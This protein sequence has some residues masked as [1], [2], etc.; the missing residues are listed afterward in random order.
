MRL[1]KMSL[2]LQMAIATVLGILAGL[3]LGDYAEIFAPYSAAYIMIL[4][5]T[6]VPYLIVAIMHGVGQLAVSQAK[7]ILKKGIIF[8]CMAWMINILIIYLIKYLFPQVE[9]GQLAGYAS[10]ETTKLNFAELL[11]PDNI[12]YDLSNNVI[13]AVVIFSLLFG[14]ALM[15]LKTEKVLMTGLQHIV[16]SLTMITSW[17][18]R[19][20]PY[21]TFLIMANQ[22]GTIQFSIFKQV[23]TYIIL[24]I[25]GICIVLFWIFPRIT[26]M[27]TP[28]SAGKWLKELSP[29]LVLAYTTNVVIVCL[30]YI[31]ELLKR[32]TQLIDP[33]DD[34]AQN[35]IQ[36]TVSIV[37]NLP[38]GSLFITVFVFF[39]SNF[40][41]ITL[42]FSSQVELFVTT[43]L[44][45][46]G[47]VGLGSWI[48]SLTFILDSLS[49]PE[50]GI[51]LYLT[52]LPFT[53][54]FQSMISAMEIATI[55][56]FITLACRNR[57]RFTWGKLAKGT[58]L[59]ALPVLLI[60]SGIKLFNPLPPIKN[61]T[62]SII[63]L[64]ISSTNPAKVLKQSIS[65]IPVEKDVF[66]RILTT[67]VLRVGYNSQAIPFCFLNTEGNVVG[68]DMAFAYELAY[69]LDCSLELVPLNYNDLANELNQG[70]YDIAMSAVTVNE[71]RLKKMTF[72]TSYMTP[73]L[74][75]LVKEVKRKQFSKLEKV[76]KLP[77][78]KIAVLKGSSFESIAKE[79]FPEKSLILL[80]SYD[81]F[82][83][84][85]T[86]VALLWEEQE[87][88][89]WSIFHRGFRVLLPD[90]SLGIDSLAYAIQANNSRFLH[91]L[92]EWLALKKA[93]GFTE[94]QVD[95]WIKGKTDIAAPDE[96]RWSI[97]RDILHW[98]D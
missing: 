85:D 97:M 31:I 17:I 70:T 94:K 68:Y 73:R 87:A 59:T 41:N 7:Q 69:D 96:L 12:F 60:A 65:S 95:L 40:Y 47:A 88:L 28:L 42:S 46:L 86:N 62:K 48:N 36:G 43:F 55:S 10:L 67:K 34:K 11:I 84:V 51:G 22:V 30:P 80:N 58:L 93:Q 75:F 24:Y 37:F 83:H 52:T 81:E 27:L 23:S 25:V 16:E 14:L 33:S 49:L 35:Q 61:E 98:H 91:Y 72:T 32:Q 45:S 13:P 50:E 63:E 4:K 54:G 8:L 74:V 21:G 38:L 39:L 82:I 20:T 44:T 66:E 26:S 5:I 79:R 76:H 71:E 9:G 57:L 2:A 18:A 29:I 15:F 90:T 53:A 89:A 1:F 92:N 3:F 56:L 6:A 19:I 64:N 77:S 78:L